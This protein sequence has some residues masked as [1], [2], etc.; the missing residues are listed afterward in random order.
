MEDMMIAGFV[1]FSCIVTVWGNRK[2]YHR[3]AIHRTIH[4]LA[5]GELKVEGKGHATMLPKEK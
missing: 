2:V 5:A 3:L 4:Q 1:W